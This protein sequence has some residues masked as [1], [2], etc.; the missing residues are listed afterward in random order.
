MNK[1][2]TFSFRSFRVAQ[3]Q[4]DFVVTVPKITSTLHGRLSNEYAMDPTYSYINVMMKCGIK[5]EH[6]NLRVSRT[7]RFQRIHA[8][9]PWSYERL[10]IGGH[11]NWKRIWYAF[12]VL[13]IL[14][15]QHRFTGYTIGLSAH[16]LLHKRGQR[17]RFNWIYCWE[18]Y[19]NKY[20]K[21]SLRFSKELAIYANLF[22]I[23]TYD[24]VINNNHPTSY[25]NKKFHL[26]FTVLLHISNDYGSNMNMVFVRFLY[27]VKVPHRH[28]FPFDIVRETKN[29][30][31]LV[32]TEHRRKLLPKSPHMGIIVLHYSTYFRVACAHQQYTTRSQHTVHVFYHPAVTCHVKVQYAIASRHSVTFNSLEIMNSEDWTPTLLWVEGNVPKFIPNVSVRGRDREGEKGREREREGKGERETYIMP[33]HTAKVLHI[34]Q[35]VSIRSEVVIRF[36][37]FRFIFPLLFSLWSIT[38]TNL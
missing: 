15:A 16:I 11:L 9:V 26:S 20:Q 27:F 22:Q 6:A 23:S 18:I 34:L 14:H 12:S 5:I 24:L 21:N 36:V 31:D 10:S 7:D 35:I 25:R 30:S 32:N 1:C 37:F 38:K 19:L 2:D 13:C 3:W 8:S 28:F 33:Q 4:T 17:V 29:I